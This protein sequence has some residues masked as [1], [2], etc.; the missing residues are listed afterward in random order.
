MSW[1]RNFDKQQKYYNK[2][3]LNY[4][5][6]SYNERTKHAPAVISILKSI[7]FPA[8]NAT[9]LNLGPL[10]GKWVDELYKTLTPNKIIFVDIISKFF[11]IIQ[12]NIDNSDYNIETE[13]IK[14]DTCKLDKIK[15]NSIHYI[16]SSDA[17][18]RSPEDELKSYFEEFKRILVKDGVALIHIVDDKSTKTTDYSISRDSMINICNN[19]NLKIISFETPFDIGTIVIVKNK[20]EKNN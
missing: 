10:K 4:N 9:L 14:I 20:R 13:F 15:N 7:K 1:T 12:K 2:K 17:I 11:K 18:T 5:M 3:K 16:W 8:D 19:L 6:D